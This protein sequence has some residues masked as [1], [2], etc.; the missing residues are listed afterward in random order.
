MKRG[1]ELGRKWF[2]GLVSMMLAMALLTG[3]GASSYDKSASA[4]SAPMKY[5]EED[6]EMEEAI[7]APTAS[8]LGD[9]QYTSQ[10]S[11]DS[12]A[13]QKNTAVTE[14]KLI[15]TVDMSVETKAYEDM[16]KALN[17]QIVAFGGYVE[18]M[19]SYN[20]SIYDSYRSNRYADMVIR[21]PADRLN[22]FLNE[23]SQLSNVVRQSESTKN[24]TLAYVDLQSRKEALTVEEDRLL[25]LL[26]I[27]ESVEDIITIE[28]RLSQ[29]RY[30]IESMESSL[31]IYDNKINYS[32]INLSIEE[33]KELTPVEEETIWQRISG[34]FLDSMESVADGFLELG[35]WLIVKSPILLVW[36][37][38]ILIVVVILRKIGSKRKVIRAAKAV[39]TADMTQAGELKKEKT[40]SK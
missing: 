27:A 29:V 15:K 38:V 11:A 32:T 16:L 36:A 14:E 5:Y 19:S 33:V 12:K 2:V 10:T 8:A 35:I 23:V 24:V 7:E 3:C 1:K 6:V 25:D 30:E 26:K 22:S 20:G 18:N 4:E 17:E 21:I 28:E 13:D 40:D 9:A 37:V 39:Q 31:R 34:G